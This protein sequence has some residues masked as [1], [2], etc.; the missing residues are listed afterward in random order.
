M[1][2]PAANKSWSGK[3]EMSRHMKIFPLFLSALVLIC[4]PSC[5]KTGNDSSVVIPDVPSEA[6]NS[7]R[8]GAV[9]E[10]VLLRG[11]YW[12]TGIPGFG[13]NGFSALTGEYRFL[14]AGGINSKTSRGNISSG[15]S[16]REGDF[17][18]YVT[19]DALF[20]SGEWQSMPGTGNGKV[21]Q[22][23]GDEGFLS[24]VILDD[25]RENSW[26]AILRF[27]QGLEGAGITTDVF[28]TMFRT[29]T[30]RLLYFLSLSKTPGDV[31]LPAALDF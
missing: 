3:N 7:L 16:G 12:I 2:K 27:P 11:N 24:A 9:N 1:E 14:P 28:N 25:G 18:A 29:W 10:A 8:T 17:L 20:F 23:S 15:E 31:S 30:S 5:E 22:R 13:V 4:I 6:D 26:V 21:Y 19:R